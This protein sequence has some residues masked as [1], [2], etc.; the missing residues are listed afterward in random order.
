MQGVRAGAEKGRQ[1]QGGWCRGEM[2]PIRGAEHTV[3][4][5]RT[6]G[7]LGSAAVGEWRVGQDGR[8]VGMAPQAGPEWA[9]GGA[10]AHVLQGQQ[11]RGSPSVH[12]D[13]H[14]A[15]T[16]GWGFVAA[17][18]ELPAHGAVPPKASARRPCCPP[19][20][21]GCLVSKEWSAVP[22]PPAPT[23]LRGLWGLTGLGEWK[24]TVTRLGIEQDPLSIMKA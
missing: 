8:H 20:M 16:P 17:A 21:R 1:R 4:A 9:V 14:Q 3:W 23:V 22:Q 13:C 19:R 2:V 5:E 15:S 18:G 24:A 6:W 12:P 10:R 7:C 11:T